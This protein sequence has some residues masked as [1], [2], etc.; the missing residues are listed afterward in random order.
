MGRITRSLKFRGDPQGVPPSIPIPALTV[1]ARVTK[2]VSFGFRQ[3]TPDVTVHPEGGRIVNVTGFRNPYLRRGLRPLTG[4]DPEVGA[5]ITQDPGFEEKYRALYLET[6]RAGV[7]YLGCIGGR[8][9][10]VYLADRLGKELG[11]P[12]EH[13]DIEVGGE[14]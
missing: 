8:H 9:R 4:M 6:H 1:F 3:G 2:I 10:S 13:R 14:K 12:V 5:F 7:L 11:I